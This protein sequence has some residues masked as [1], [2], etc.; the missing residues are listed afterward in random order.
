MGTSIDAY[1]EYDRTIYFEP[2]DSDKLPFSSSVEAIDLR[3][4]TL[5]RSG[6][7][8][9][10]ISAISGFRNKTDKQPLYQLRGLPSIMSSEAEKGLL[11]FYDPNYFGLGWLTLSEINQ[12]LAHFGLERKDLSLETNVVLQLMSFLDLKLGVDRVRLVFGIE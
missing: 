3:G 4:F 11:E 7:D 10:F 5:F 12:S 9:S 2:K 1:I 8:Y 6:K